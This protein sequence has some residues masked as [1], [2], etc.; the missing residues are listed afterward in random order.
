MLH[1]IADDQG[2]PAVSS[3]ISHARSKTE[4]LAFDELA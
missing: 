1:S 2:F 4:I 3:H